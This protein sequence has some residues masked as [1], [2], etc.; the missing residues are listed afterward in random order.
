MCVKS[1]DKRDESDE[2]DDYRD[3]LDDSVKDNN[4]DTKIHILEMISN[5]I[6]SLAS[7]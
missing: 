1:C 7:S 5:N 6:N 3:K 2:D 4:E